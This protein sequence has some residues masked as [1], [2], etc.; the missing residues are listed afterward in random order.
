MKNRSKIMLV[1]CA[2]AACLCFGAGCSTIETVD[3]DQSKIPAYD[4]QHDVSWDTGADT[5][6][7]PSNDPVT[8]DG[9][10]DEEI[11]SENAW[12][13]YTTKNTDGE[14]LGTSEINVKGTVVYGEEGFYTA[15][16]VSNSFVF[17]DLTHTRYAFY[18]SGV[19]VYIG[20]PGD[21]KNNYEICLIPDGFVRV[22]TWMGTGF[23]DG[24]LNGIVSMG[25]VKGEINTFEAD[26]YYIETYFPWSAFGYTEA[27]CAVQMDIAVVQASSADGERDGWESLG[28]SYNPNWQWANPQSYWAWG[29]GGFETAPLD[30]TL[31]EYD[32]SMGSVSLAAE[33]YSA[34]DDIVLNIV[35]EEGY[36][37]SSVL[38]N[39]AQMR[40]ALEGTTL[41]LADYSGTKALDIAV[42]FVAISDVRVEVSGTVTAVAGASAAWTVPAQSVLTFS[43]EA[44]TF[45]ATVGE[46][47]TYTASLPYGTFS[48]TVNGYSAQ[49]VV[50][51]EG[52]TDP[53]TRNLQLRY[54]LIGTNANVTVSED[55][56]TATP[57]AI[58]QML[59]LNISSEQFTLSFRANIRSGGS[60]VDG[61]GA[62]FVYGNN[63]NFSFQCGFIDNS[64]YRL[65]VTN[66]G[67]W[68]GQ[69]I[70]VDDESFAAGGVEVLI[71]RD[72]DT[73]SA[74]YRLEDGDW[75]QAVSVSQA[76][77]TAIYLFNW[78]ADAFYT[79]I[80]YAPS[81]ELVTIEA[82]VTAQYGSVTL[83]DEYIIGQ[84]VVLN[85]APQSGFAL[86]GITVNGTDM[87]ASVS[88]GTLTVEN[89]GVTTLTV[90]AT[91]VPEAG[92][93]YEIS[94]TATAVAGASDAWS[95]PDGT[96]LTFTGSITQN[97]TVTGG[98]YSVELP[99]GEFVVS[100]QGYST[101]TITVT[102]DATENIS[103][104]YDLLGTPLTKDVTVSEDESTVTPGAEFQMVPLNTTAEQF[105]LYFK[106]NVKEGASAGDGLGFR[107]DFDNSETSYNFDNYSFQ[108]G[109]ID[110]GFAL[111]I[112]NQW[113]GKYGINISAGDYAAGK[114]EVLIIRDGNDYM[115]YY[116]IPGENWTKAGDTLTIEATRL[117]MYSWSS[118]VYFSDIAFAPT[119]ELVTIRTDVTAEHGS[120]SLA[121][122]YI[123]GET[124]TLNVTPDSGHILQSL[125]VNGQEMAS[126]VTNGKLSISAC[127]VETLS[128]TA[129]FISQ[130]GEGYV[131]SGAATAVAGTSDAW[132]IP[133]GTV[134]TFT[135]DAVYTAEV[136]ADGT[137]SVRL[138]EGEYTVTANGYGS[139][140]ITVSGETDADILLRY[141][142]LGTNE[143]VAIG[144]DEATLT[145][146]TQYNGVAV[147]TTAEQFTIS[148]KVNLKE[149]G[150][151]A[152][153]IGFKIL[154]SG[155]DRTFQCGYIDG[156]W[157]IRI[158][159][160]DWVGAVLPVDDAAVTQNGFEVMIVR[161]GNV[162]TAYYRLPDKAWTYACSVETEVL[163]YELYN[164]SQDMYFTDISFAPSFELVEI[165]TIINATTNGSVT[166]VQDGCLLGDDVTFRVIPETGYLLQSILVNGTE[167]ASSVT[168][169]GTLVISDC[170][171]LELTVSAVFAEAPDETFTVSGTATAV[172]GASEAWNI[173]DG[174]VLSFVGE[175][176]QTAE[177]TDGAYS[178][179]LA[180]GV[181]TVSAQ[182]YGSQT[183]IVSAAATVNILLRYDLLGSNEN[184]T[185]SEDEATLT[186]STQYNGVA[187]NTTA[188]QFTVSF[189]VNLKE[190]GSAADGIG[191][192][193][194]TADGDYTFQCGYIT[195]EG[196]RLRI[197]NEWSGV[198]L[199]VT[200]TEVAANG[201]EV[202]IVC[203]GSTFTAYY[204]LSGGEWTQ[205]C[206]LRA[207]A[208][209]YELYNWS[210][211]M[212]FTDISYTP[213]LTNAP[214]QN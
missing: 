91:F 15:F 164:W 45:S 117:S 89:C 141:D 28:V 36:T 98:T 173:P 153:G 130:A 84:D 151:A 132:T 80:S 185:I 79:D 48:A 156:A 106:V 199:P 27:P 144:E 100:V 180:A 29:A 39:G 56:T 190:D 114:F 63:Q 75:V 197:V 150:N 161:D 112:A 88:E 159:N 46:N 59:P 64:S 162:Y 43:G 212:Y 90:V 7:V 41:T 25:T 201:I 209:S 126:S 165:D 4:G 200:D 24:G 21:S 60:A 168:A 78:S 131:V 96:T 108:T 11:Y 97:V 61:L 51:E 2:L 181:Y 17:V 135:G 118:D 113:S 107:I 5:P 14:G 121:D 50:V 83:A 138:P 57:G 37:V 140:K 20:F 76:D 82:D 12:M 85:I 42:E 10:L 34:H 167:M 183:V 189:K 192:K 110:G 54:D 1:I 188:E 202:M 116:R 103:L 26:G 195:G 101:Q 205:A 172:A 35:P 93:M 32:T 72:G 184:V 134:L 58:E 86:S 187:V 52:V 174:V 65:R 155:S 152:D 127:G 148:F 154:I 176:T 19:S 213:D 120:V 40:D 123:I 149:G 55:E 81:F 198:T 9:V 137:Y 142:L 163:S 62:M 38:V 145:P 204:R 129:V 157:R 214:T 191:F 122:S 169:D 68:A 105:S 67:G 99:E 175:V 193:L 182:G 139:R 18:D 102:G 92:E 207:T 87:T 74:F 203:D 208:V 6:V 211:D 124:V 115:A 95:L 143:N 179:E 8:V 171:W 16:E 23:V 71:I 166:L 170:G 186:P 49:E 104:V 177:V 53:V 73:Y 77:V 3:G 133:E 210:Q 119:H 125:L 66:I 13:D 47:G 128:I 194:F 44:G 69:N 111:R 136:S 30:I 70:P 31:G 178:V 146:S 109:Y 160:A 22:A 196:W 206:S 147:N 158:T 94:G 33:S